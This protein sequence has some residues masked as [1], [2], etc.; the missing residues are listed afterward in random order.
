MWQYFI[1][2]SLNKKGKDW[3][4]IEQRVSNAKINV[5]ERVKEGIDGHCVPE[6][7]LHH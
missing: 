6:E 7:T 5:L 1:E 2:D 3:R 4:G